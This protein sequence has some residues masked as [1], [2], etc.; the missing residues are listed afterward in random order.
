MNRKKE[1]FPFD[2]EGL[3]GVGP[4]Y[5]I[6]ASDI[7]EAT[8]QTQRQIL[9][10]HVLRQEKKP[11]PGG[12][13]NRSEQAKT[14]DD[15]WAEADEILNSLTDIL[16]ER[17]TAV[18]PSKRVDTS[19][20]IG[21]TIRAMLRSFLKLGSV[22]GILPDEEISNKVFPA[23]EELRNRV[24]MFAKAIP[25]SDKDAEEKWGQTAAYAAIYILYL[26]QTKEESEMG[27]NEQG[28]GAPRTDRVLY[29][30]SKK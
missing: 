29:S 5:P 16:K 13:P 12:Q 15:Y 4:G 11:D 26:S 6:P 22:E 17:P 21:P 28:I 3:N 23:G 18:D 14:A 9:S 20:C 30:G 19:I 10:L 7:H 1:S 25:E 8:S 27:K 24:K 2:Q